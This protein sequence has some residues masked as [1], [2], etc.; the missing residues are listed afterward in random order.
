MFATKKASLQAS[1][2][3]KGSS[4]VDALSVRTW[5]TYQILIIFRFDLAILGSLPLWLQLRDGVIG[6]I[7]A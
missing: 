2:P 5:V 3:Q 6:E 4:G 1:T 7:A